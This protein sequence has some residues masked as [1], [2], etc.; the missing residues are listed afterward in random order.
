MSAGTWTVAQAK[1]KFSRL[2]QEAE[3]RGP[4]TVTRNGHV[5]V[6]VVGAEEW[7]NKVKRR[8][9]LA[10]FLLNSPLRGSDAKIKPV[11]IRLRKSV[12]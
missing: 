1:A 3:T 2:V 5:T 4:Q 6:V 10:E 7:H 11:P 12:L 9:N 8:G